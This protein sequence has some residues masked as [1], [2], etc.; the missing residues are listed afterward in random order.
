[1][2]R[3]ILFFSFIF[4]FLIGS[5]KFSSGDESKKI[6]TT[7]IKNPK[8]FNMLAAYEKAQYPFFLISDSGLMMHEETLY[9]MALCMTEDVGLVHQMPFTCDRKGFA[10]TVEKVC[11]SKNKILTKKKIF[12]SNRIGLFRYTTCSYVYDN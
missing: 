9:D 8:I 11:Y 10:G 7:E 6:V 4:W 2:N 5:Q 3:C 12:F 1:M